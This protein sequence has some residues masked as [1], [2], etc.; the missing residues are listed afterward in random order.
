MASSYRDRSVA[1]RTRMVVFGA[2]LA[3]GLLAAIPALANDNHC[4]FTVAGGTTY[5]VCDDHWHG[6]GAGFLISTSIPSTWDQRLQAAAGKWNGQTKYHPGV[7]SRVASTDPG[8]G[9]LIWLGQI[10]AA[11]AAGCPTGSTLACTGTSGLI[12]TTLTTPHGSGTRLGHITDADIVFNKAFKNEFQTNNLLCT[13]NVGYDV[14]TVA[15]HELGHTGGLDHAA[16]ATDT[17][18]ASYSKCARALNDHGSMTSLYTHA[19]H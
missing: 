19:G 15:L 16:A 9:H 2:I 11:W 17:M 13:A 12:Y 7:G 10:P 18:F 8:V 3:V 4:Y 6:T 5:H 14:Q 1:S